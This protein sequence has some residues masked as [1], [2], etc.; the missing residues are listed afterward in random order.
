MANAVHCAF[1]RPQRHWPYTAANKEDEEAKNAEKDQIR[2]KR[3]AIGQ[4]AAQL[5]ENA[6][7]NEIAKQF[8]I[9]IGMTTD[10][11]HWRITVRVCI[12]LDHGLTTVVRLAAVFF[13]GCVMPVLTVL[14][15][16]QH[17]TT[18]EDEKSD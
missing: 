1:F 18:T 5:N 15:H 13:P 9:L 11:I 14:A 6:R 10:A 2:K 3:S 4:L 8:V 12:D 7:D 17:W 16:E